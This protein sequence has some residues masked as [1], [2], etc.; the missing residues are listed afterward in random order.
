V[1]TNSRTFQR[2][3]KEKK[4]H[5][6]APSEYGFY[7]EPRWCSERLFRYEEFKGEVVDPSCGT[8]RVVDAA[9][10]SG[11]RASGSDIVNRRFDFAVSDFFDLAEAY[12]VY[13]NIAS[14]PPFHRADE[15]AKLAL[16]VSRR[17]VALLLPAVWHIAETRS[18]WLQRSPLRRV[19]FLTPRPS[20][21]PGA[22][23]LAGEKPSGGTSDFAWYVWEHGYSGTPEMR[24]LR[25]DSG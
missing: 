17:K 20:M 3:V 19:W 15:Y 13:D 4:A 18:I 12:P 8:G 9:R 14:N 2:L 11:L 23:I 22:V 25:R 16:Q 7:I 24:W 21:P 10:R 1:T 5:I 6:W